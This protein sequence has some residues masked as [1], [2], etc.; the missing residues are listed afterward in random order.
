[1]ARTLA[2]QRRF[3]ELQGGNLAAAVAFQA[4]VSLLPLVVVA[5]GV[6]GFVSAGAWFEVAAR[7]VGL[8]GLTGVAARAIGEG[9][10]GAA[11]SR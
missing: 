10:A 9:V 11:R 4:F 3:R 8:L 5:V 1:M 2:V 6:V 7:I